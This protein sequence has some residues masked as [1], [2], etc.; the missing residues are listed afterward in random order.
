MGRLF[1][2]ISRIVVFMLFLSS[3]EVHGQ[4]DLPNSGS[5]REDFRNFY[6]QPDGVLLSSDLMSLDFEEGQDDEYLENNYEHMGIMVYGATF[7]ERS[8]SLNYMQ[9]PPR[10]GKT[11]IYDDKNLSNG[12]EIHFDLNLTGAV[13]YVVMYV[14][15]LF[16][17]KI[18][19]MDIEGF[20]IEE[21]FVDPNYVGAGTPN[22]EVVFQTDVSIASLH[23]TTEKSSG[24]KYLGNSFTI[25]DFGIK[26]TKDCLNEVPLYSQLDKSYGNDSYGEPGWVSGD[27]YEENIANYGC[28]LVSTAMTISYYAN[29]YGKSPVNPREL[30]IWLR[31][32]EGYKGGSILFGI[33]AKYARVVKG[34][35]VWFNG[36]VYSRD[37]ARVRGYICNRHPVVLNVRTSRGSHFVLARGADFEGDFQ[38]NDPLGKPTTL[39][40][41]YQGL[42]YS[43][44]HFSDIESNKVLELIVNSDVKILFID[45]LGRKFGTDIFANKHFAEIYGSSLYIEEVFPSGASVAVSSNLDDSYRIQR[46]DT[47]SLPEGKYS[48]YIQSDQGL[49]FDLTLAVYSKNFSQRLNFGGVLSNRQPSKLISFRYNSQT[50]SEDQLVTDVFLTD[51]KPGESFIFLPVAMR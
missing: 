3:L 49:P 45:S 46:F 20:V 18:E 6:I 11:V 36:Y 1:Y 26:I 30:N 42:Y 8:G 17:L 19:V 2:A 13:N 23:L 21:K 22:K 10:S 27:K 48:I 33:A 47:S 38:L 14:T 34:I 43:S 41:S 16:P 28:A 35:P 25:D 5:F 50:M 31:D 15:T 51:A 9:Y 7:L 12:V 37:D 4:D 32:N 39:S 40:E 44:R 29:I 24:H